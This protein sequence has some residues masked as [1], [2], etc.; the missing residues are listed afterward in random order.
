M[1]Q[2]KTLSSA[3]QLCDL[4]LL[5]PCNHEEADTRLFLHVADVANKGT[6]KVIVRTVDSDVVI[7]AVAVFQKVK[8][9]EMWI[10]FGAG[11]H[12]CYIGIHNVVT[13]LGPSAGSALLFHW[14]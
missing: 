4:S 8:L 6:K 7:L 3:V 5:V 11:S 2:K 9:E 12:F 10:A 13:A 1:P 14:L